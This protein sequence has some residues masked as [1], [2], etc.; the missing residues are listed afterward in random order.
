MRAVTIRNRSLTWEE[1]QDPVPL[2]GELLVR[3]GAAGVNGADILQRDGRYPPPPGTVDDIPGLEVAGTIVAKGD[4]VGQSFAIG[5]RVMALVAGGGQAELVAVNERTVMHIPPDLSWEEAGA[6]PEAFTTAHDAL[7]VQCGLVKGERV[8]IHGA[9]GGVGAAAVQLAVSLGC[10]VVATVR[11]EKLR[12]AV[13]SLGASVI[14]PDQFQEKGPF[15]V[16]LELVGAVNMPGNLESLAVGGR[17][18]VIGIGAGTAAEIDL[19]TLMSRR[20]TIHGSTLSARTLDQKAQAIRRIKEDV[21]PL[22]AN[23]TVRVPIA[24][25]YPM[26][27]AAAAYSRFTE[28]GKF[29]KVVLIDD[30]AK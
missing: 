29:G 27:E 24:A 21:L 23:S 10:S 18:S 6:F 13:S 28:G 2:V 19:R 16:I 14:A 22:L 5:D 8:L 15:D 26:S 17:I 9:A 1:R 20:G 11:N 4:D 30:N 12:N 25:T 7:F 3:V